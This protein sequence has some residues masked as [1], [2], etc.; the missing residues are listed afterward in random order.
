MTTIFANDSLAERIR[1]C[2]IELLVQRGPGRSVCPSEVAR[3]VGLRTNCRWQDLMR[4]VRT[5]AATLA[6]SGVID[7]TQ[8][9]AVVDIRAVRGP[10]RLRLRTLHGERNIHAA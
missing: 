2:A 1:D 5:V 8:H 7:V 3:L 10:I 6:E 4:P 9:D